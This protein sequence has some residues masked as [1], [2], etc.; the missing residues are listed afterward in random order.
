M[1][2]TLKPPA[3]APASGGGVDFFLDGV[4]TAAHPVPIID[5]LRDT[6]SVIGE[7][8]RLLRAKLRALSQERSIEVMALTSALPGEGKSTIAL[9]LATALAREVGSSVLLV[10][11]DMRRPSISKMLGAP[12]APGLSEWLNGA[13]DRIPVRTVQPGGFQLLSAGEAPLESPESVGS[14]LMEALLVS[15]RTVYDFVLLDGPPVLAVSDTILLQ[16]LVDGLLVVVR[17]RKTPREGVLDALGRLR[18]EK[19]LGVVLN[20]HKEYRHSYRNYAYERYGMGDGSRRSASRD[21]RS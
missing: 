16:D 14:P 12:P 13:L 7:E 9:G 1:T 18:A 10:E 2:D 3:Q 15:A 6:H 17:S 8:L 5:S 11:A 19:I 20:D 21:E 4:I